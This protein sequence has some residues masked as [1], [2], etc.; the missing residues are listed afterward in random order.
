M[1]VA[2]PIHY[3]AIMK[4]HRLYILLGLWL[5]LLFAPGVVLALGFFGQIDAKTKISGVVANLWIVGYLLQ[6][7]V[8][9][10]IMRITR[11]QKFVWWLGASLLPWAIDWTL[12]LNLLYAPLWLAIAVGMIVWIAVDARWDASMQESGIRGVGVVLEVFRPWMNVVINRVY[13]KRKLRLRIERNDGA[14]PYEVLYKG[15]FMIGNIPSPGDRIPLLIDPAN[16]KRFEYNAGGTKASS[17]S[18]HDSS[19]SSQRKR[20]VADELAK[21]A[22]LHDRGALSDAQFEAAKNKVFRE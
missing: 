16:P 19:S 12:P 2:V 1:T 11:Q 10:V 7:G 14:A 8:F 9:M 21:L 3:I 4:L 22:D 17:T 15:L 18:P 20:S 5:V 13:I 6:F